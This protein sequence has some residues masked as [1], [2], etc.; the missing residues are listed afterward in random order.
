[1]HAKRVVILLSRETASVSSHMLRGPCELLAE[2]GIVT[3]L[4][5][6]QPIKTLTSGV[7]ENTG[8]GVLSRN[9]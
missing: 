3:G 5:L 9:A 8:R 7:H 6:M 4:S 1:L 2:E